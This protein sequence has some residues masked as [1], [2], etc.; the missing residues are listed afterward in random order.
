M[1]ERLA[2]VILV[3][4]VCLLHMANKTAPH[5]DMDLFP[6]NLLHMGDNQPPWDLCQPEPETLDTVEPTPNDAEQFTHADRHLQRPT[7]KQKGEKKWTR[8]Q[9]ELACSTQT[10]ARSQRQMASQSGRLVPLPL[11]ASHATPLSLPLNLDPGTH[12]R[13][14]L[15]NVT[16]PLPRNINYADVTL[17]S[18]GWPKEHESC[19]TQFH[20]LHCLKSKQ[21]WDKRWHP[22]PEKKRARSEINDLSSA[23]KCYTTSRG[24]TSVRFTSDWLK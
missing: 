8:K 6:V 19:P 14:H 1:K 12:G 10:S 24:L 9:I 21:L 3:L 16:P 4:P 23:G 18:G 15:A 7:Y 5:Y 17:T 22:R 11:P 20:L 2:V 13:W